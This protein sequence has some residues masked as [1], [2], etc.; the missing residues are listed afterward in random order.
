MS[1]ERTII[2]ASTFIGV[3]LA[4]QESVV[5]AIIKSSDTKENLQMT[6]MGKESELLRSSNKFAM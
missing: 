2:S 6:Y 5:D 4:L 3:A 1:E